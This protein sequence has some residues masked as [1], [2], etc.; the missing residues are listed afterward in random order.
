LAQILKSCGSRDNHNSSRS[1]KHGEVAG[2]RAAGVAEPEVYA[3][4]TLV[5][6]R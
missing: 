4:F 2:L 6:E 3:Q 5:Q 1:G